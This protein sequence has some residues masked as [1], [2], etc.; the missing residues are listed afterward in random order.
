MSSLQ[1]DVKCLADIRA[2]A[3]HPPGRGAGRLFPLPLTSRWEGPR[4]RI[5]PPAA[6]PVRRR[7]ENYQ[8]NGKEH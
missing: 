6:S 3:P 5:A 1:R 7:G 2:A 4:I 8:Q